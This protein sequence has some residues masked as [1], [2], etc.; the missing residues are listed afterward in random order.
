GHSIQL[1][2]QVICVQLVAH[3]YHCLYV[4]FVGNDKIT[5]SFR[6]EIK[7]ILV[8]SPEMQIHHILFSNCLP[9]AKITSK[10]VAK[11]ACLYFSPTLPLLLPKKQTTKLWSNTYVNSKRN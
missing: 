4:A 6:Q 5:F 10:P 8:S 7:D 11:I 9:L 3:L 1:P 2:V